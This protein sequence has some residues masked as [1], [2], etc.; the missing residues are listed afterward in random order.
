MSC[1]CLP[2]KTLD[3]FYV[4]GS[5][6]LEF[7][8]LLLENKAEHLMASLPMIELRNNPQTAADVVYPH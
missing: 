5:S 7:L 8:G 3:F 6:S 1:L 4:E 2:K